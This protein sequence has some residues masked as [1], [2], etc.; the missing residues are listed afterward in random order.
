MYVP[1]NRVR[2][3]RCHKAQVWIVRVVVVASFGQPSIRAE[4][5]VLHRVDVSD[6]AG[7]VCTRTWHRPLRAVWAW[8]INKHLIF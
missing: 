1:L 6:P 7:I 3:V 2:H 4:R 5:K 8:K